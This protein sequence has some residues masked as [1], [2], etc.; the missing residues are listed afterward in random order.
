VDQVIEEIKTLP[1]DFIFVDDNIVADPEYAARLF[2]KLIPLKKRWVSQCS[3]KIA[4]DPELLETAYRA[5]CKGLFIGVET[6]AV[7]NLAAVSK[8]FNA[9][10]DYY[11][12]I[13]AIRKR[14]IGI[15]A[16]M[17]VGMDH[18]DT[19]VFEKTLRFLQK[20]GIE[21]L[22]LNILTPLPGT[23]LYDDFE[24]AGRIVDHNWS[25]YDFRH[26]VIE[27][28]RMSAAQ[29]KDG[30][31]WLYSRFYRLDQILIRTV[32]TVFTVGWVPA[33]LTW[34]LGMT[35]RYDNKREKVKGRNPSPRSTLFEKVRVC[36]NRMLRGKAAQHFTLPRKKG[37]TYAG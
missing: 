23:P 12:R 19:T 6:L 8:Q 37:V 1:K 2:K 9:Q 30:A 11:R 31:D 36:I 13:A 22:Q 15:V 16:G 24:R 7:E 33:W 29:L 14:G 28:A 27:P 26:C 35:Y 10:R 3:L 25:R 4:D 21:V 34:R 17:I 32:K 20:T 5:G 18:D